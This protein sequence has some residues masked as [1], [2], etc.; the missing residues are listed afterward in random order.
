[1]AGGTRLKVLNALDG[2]TTDKLAVS[3]AAGDL[4]PLER[5]FIE[6]RAR[7][8]RVVWEPD[9]EALRTPVLQ[10]L[11]VAWRALSPGPGRPPPP[12]KAQEL[13]TG[14]DSDWTML[15]EPSQP[16]DAE[17]PSHLERFV[18]RHYGAGI[19]RSYGRD[20]TG[21]TMHGFP[22][23][24]GL[25]FA[26]IYTAVQHRPEPVFTE[27]EPPAVVLVRS[28]QRLILPF[29]EPGRAVSHFV[30]GNVPESAVT[31]LLDVMYDAALVT[32]GDGQFVL[33]TAP[34]RSCSGLARGRSPVARSIAIWPA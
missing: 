31:T 2:L 3:I 30:V 24:I 27:H 15:L 32:D 4:A 6:A 22:G 10:R 21:Q 33:P 20:M 29:A 8:P 9:P 17:R 34:P 13:A 11:L 23:H 18:Y 16:I 25:F 5:L 26:A 14:N 28:W 12:S 1:M 19:A 7:P